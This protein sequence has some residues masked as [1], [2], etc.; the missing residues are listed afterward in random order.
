MPTTS[1]VVVGA[2]HAGLA[3][4]RHLADLSIDHVVLE[5]GEVANSWRT[6]RWESLRLLTPNWMTRLPGFAYPGD[7]PGG[8]QSAADFARLVT[9]YAEVCDAPVLTG[10]RVTRVAPGGLGFDVTTFSGTWHARA[11][12]MAVGA[13]RAAVPLVSRQLP[14]DLVSL[15]ALDYRH[16]DQLPSGGVLV[17]GA[18]ASGVQIAEELQ[19]SGRPV[20]L[21]VG[22]HVRAPR[23]YRDRD[24]LWWM[25]AIGVLDERYDEVDDLVRAR[26]LPSLQ[27][28]GGPRDVD[29]NALQAAGVQVVGRFAGIRHG[30]AQL[31]GSLANV[32]S[33]ADLKLVRLLDRI[34]EYA[35]GRGERPDPTHVPRARLGMDLGSG[36]I[37]SVVWATGFQPDHSLL[38]LPV[39]DPHGRLRHDGGVAPWP[40]LYVIGLPL[41]RR[42]RS[43]YIDGAR[44]DA[45]DLAAHLAGHLGLA[46]AASRGDTAP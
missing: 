32:C 8:Y 7:D 22:E 16:P 40:G 9:H 37:R 5:R 20:T 15:P 31:S 26:H 18:S 42:R 29:L 1:V 4:S 36:E 35:G 44:S 11:V 45:A 34:D 14:D 28:V 46:G 27:L 19:L 24:L 17:V 6:Q 23:R 3:M 39:F 25:D 12:V 10:T 21:A 33:L 2:G 43:T 30:Q 13:T 38:D 41:L